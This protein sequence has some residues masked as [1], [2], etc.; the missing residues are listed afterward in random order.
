L[1][2]SQIPKNISRIFERLKDIGLPLIAEY[3]SKRA[4]VSLDNRRKATVVRMRSK[5]LA[6][7]NAEMARAMS[8]RDLQDLGV[9]ESFHKG[10]DPDAIVL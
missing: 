4:T 5:T 1:L 3:R 7:E 10:S 9:I 6:S 2:T 8:A